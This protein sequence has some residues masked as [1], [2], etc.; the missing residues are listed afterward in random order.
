VL[1]NSTTKINLGKG[2]SLF[3]FQYV[4]VIC[5]Q[6]WHIST[7]YRHNI[8]D[9]SQSSFEE[10]LYPTEKDIREQNVNLYYIIHNRLCL[11]SSHTLWGESSRDSMFQDDKHGESESRLEGG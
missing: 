10:S 2:V 11:R 8:T 7:N 5:L 3:T 1:G 4:S 6:G 9:Q